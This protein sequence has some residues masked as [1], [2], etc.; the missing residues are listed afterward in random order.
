MDSDWL[1]DPG[2]S[3]R[4]FA[5][6]LFHFIIGQVVDALSFQ[7]DLSVSD[8]CRFSEQTDDGVTDHGLAGPGLPDNT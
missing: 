7:K 1:T 8:M 6:D 4:Y 5:A 3:R 2:K